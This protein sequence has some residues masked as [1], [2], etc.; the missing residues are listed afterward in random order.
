MRTNYW[1]KVLVLMVVGAMAC[2]GV[3]QAETHTEGFELDYNLG[4]KIGTHSDWYDGGNGPTVN[5]GIGV[6]GSVGLSPA[7]AIFNWV[8]HPFNWNDVTKVIIRM[9]FQTDGSGH[10]DDDRCGWTINSGSVNSADFFGTQL[11][12]PDGGIVTY[13]RN[14]SGSRVQTPIVVFGDLKAGTWYRFRNEMTKLTA[15]SA[16]LDV[17]LDELDAAGNPIGSPLTGTVEDTSA[18]P[19]GAPDTKYFTASTIWP[20]YKNYTTAAAAADNAYFEIV[21]AG[22]VPTVTLVSPDDESLVKTTE[23]SF[24]CSATSEDGLQD[25]ALYVGEVPV[26]V[27]FSGADDTDDA[28]LYATD[29]SATPEV[30]GPDTNAGTAA[31]INVDGVNP[32]SHAVIKFL[33][34]FGDEDG[35]VP[36]GSTIISATLKVNCFN[37]GALMQVYRVTS[38]WSE[39]TV[40]WN[41]PWTSP[42]GDYDDTVVVDGDC[43][44]TGL[45]TIDITEFVQAWSDWA[46]NFGIVLT[47][48]GGNDGIDF[49]SSESGSPPVLTVTY[50]SDFEL[51]ETRLMSGTSDTVTFGPITLADEQDHVWN[52]LVTNVSSEQSWAPADFHLTVNT[53]CPDEP[54]VVQPADDATDVSTSPEL[55]VTVS[56]PQG[57]LMD[58]TFYGRGGALGDEFTIVVL[59]DT[60]NYCEFPEN[61]H[62][63]TEQTQWIVDNIGTRNIVFVTH[64]GDIVEHPSSMT[65]YDRARSS[66]SVLDPGLADLSDPMLPDPYVLY[67]VCPGNHDQPTGPPPSGYYNEYF[68]Y[69]H[70]ESRELDWYGG[71][72]PATGNDNNYQLFSAG[73]MDF[74]IL[75]LEYNPGSDVITWADQALYDHADRMA[76][77]TTHAYLNGDGSRRAEGSAIWDT[78]VQQNDNV[79]FVLCGHMQEEARRTDVVNGREV[80]QILA[81]YQGRA[82]GG[83]GWLR[84]MR[85]VPAEDTVYVDTYSPSLEQYETDGDSQFT[86]NLPMNFYEEIGTNTGVA[87]GSNASVVWSDLL[88]GKEYEWFVEVTDTAEHTQVGP[89][90]SFTTIDNPQQASNPSPADGVVDVAVDVDLSWTAGEGATSHDVYFS[91]FTPPLLV[92]ENLPEVETTYDPGTLEEGVT[93]YWRIDEVNDT[94]TYAGN[95]WS[96]TTSIEAP[97]IATLDTPPDG[98]I[99]VGVGVSLRWLSG[100]RAA[101]HDVYFGVSYGQVDE[102]TNDSPEFQCNI[103]QEAG[104]PGAGGVTVFSW[105]PLGTEDLPYDSSYWWRIDEIN[106]G[107]TTKGDIW[108]FTTES[109]TSPPIF[110]YLW[111]SFITAHEATITWTTNELSDSKVDYGLV[112]GSYTESVYDGDE[113]TSHSVTLTGLEPGT[114]YYYM[115]TSTDQAEPPNS[116]SEVGLPF[117]TLA[118]TPPVA[119]N[120][121]A[122]TTEGVAVVID[123]LVNDSDENGDTLTVESVTFDPAKAT[124]ETDGDTVTYTPIL[125]APYIDTFTYTV[126]DGYL[127]TDTATV[128][129]EV[130]EP[131]VDYTA[132]AEIAVFGTVTGSYTDTEAKDDS[133]EVI[134]EGLD[135]PN[136]NAASILEHKWLI[137]VPGTGPQSFHVNAYRDD[138]D[139]ADDFVFAYSTNDSTYTEMLTVTKTADDGMYQTYALPGSVSGTV[140]I[141][142]SDTH[143]VNGELVTGQVHVD[144]MFI[145]C[146]SAGEPDTTAPTPDPMTWAEAPQATGSTSISMTATTASDSSGVEYY[147]ACIT[148]AAHDSGWQDSPIYEDTGLTSGT[149][150]TYQVQA[151]DKSPNQNDTGWSSPASATPTDVPPAA[152]TGLAATPGDSQISLDWNDNTEP[153]LDGYNVYRSETSG[154]Y[155]APLAFVTESA[156]VDNDVVNGTTYYYVVT[157]VDQTSNESGNSNEASATPGSQQTVYVE[158]INMSLVSA[159]QNT[160]AVAGVHISPGQSGATVVGDWYFS[161]EVIQTGASGITDGTGYTEFTSAPKKA[162]S[163]DVFEFVV[164]DVVL[165][166]YIYDPGQ[167]VTSGSIAVP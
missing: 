16:R 51:K 162:K 131:Y 77:I 55:V 36:L 12:H 115:V 158:N 20:A 64:E 86:L 137:S 93:Y 164:T 49:Y 34:V 68:P 15:T 110:T 62:I 116:A 92:S 38:D 7:S 54:V 98:A 148:D 138:Y 114:A 146:E 143:H 81:D 149:E 153:D 144:H 136:K 21:P 3:A 39:S 46:A 24:T 32:H 117:T 156:Y 127:G 88:L 107:G 163:G 128:T 109:D 94:T 52:C 105:N 19:G 18:W 140:Y 139:S 155:G 79:Y 165:S 151:R 35:Q 142:V 66:M 83:D 112:D 111:V 124:V 11:D 123:V 63:F 25:A 76:I 74:V 108:S 159:G 154:S 48:S 133:Y 71:H 50:G 99:G 147:F 101:S 56:D 57:D 132:D 91:A 31:T 58:V 125:A 69:T 167:G 120:D 84:I 95:V 45:R 96:F 5:S 166:G 6:V 67:G 27:T 161:G 29:D 113:V 23:V 26:T 1:K 72:W 47:D 87:S 70:Y 134:E 73:G 89:T 122:T 14:D 65:E 130:S 145:R 4:E 118:N 75:H 126:N 17:S 30:E 22:P 82:N 10:F 13:W 37:F 106:P 129:V 141:R 102:A 28:Q 104:V 59:P 150:Y 53:Q 44:A 9:D 43:T 61:A 100:E 119:V 121:S 152:P 103:L 2:V 90:W 42:G 97:G 160:K 40:T 78:L 60:Q 8:A 135:K 41:S 80:H 33:N 85:F 157:A